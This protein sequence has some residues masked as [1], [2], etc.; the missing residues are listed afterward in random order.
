M[1]FQSM[2][3]QRLEPVGRSGNDIIYLCP[4]CD[5][6]SGH[7]YINYDKGYYH[8]FKCN[9]SGKRLESLLKKL[10]ID[11]DY[12]YTKLYNEQDKELDSII[13][14]KEDK[15]KSMRLE[16]VVDYSTDL[17]V[18][19]QYYN[20]HTK[21]LS[22]EAYQ[23]LLNRNMTPDL[24]ARLSIREGVN[25]YGDIININGKEY[26]GR[27]YSGRIM[28]PSLRRDGRISFY[29]GRDYIGDKPAKYMNPPKELGAASEDVWNLDMIESDS[30]IICEGVFTAIAASPYKLNSVATYGKSI[31]QRSSNDSGITVTSQG[32]KL[33]NKKFKNYYVAYDADAHKEAIKSCDYLYDRGA[34][35]YLILIDPKKYGKKADVADIGY[36]EF[37]KLMNNAIHYDGGISSLTF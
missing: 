34:N 1:D 16:K 15:K 22:Y 26:I 19:T 3:E 4:Q 9:L 36:Q 18:L 32:E 33:L 7:L 28:V 37:L 6:K 31:A 13:A 25:R 10:H 12:D 30:V 35:V 29:V 17:N 20:L 11:I 8:C 27:D 14:I 23:Y 24:I 21:P 5:D 2:I